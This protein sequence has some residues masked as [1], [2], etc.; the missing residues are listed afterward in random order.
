M[1][2]VLGSDHPATLAARTNLDRER[3]A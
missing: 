1:A 2:R 3:G